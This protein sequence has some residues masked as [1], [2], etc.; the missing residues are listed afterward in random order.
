MPSLSQ[1]QPHPAFKTELWQ[2]P[3]TRPSAI[4]K[5]GGTTVSFCKKESIQLA[6][7][8]LRPHNESE[9]LLGPFEA[10]LEASLRD[11]AVTA[12]LPKAHAV[13]ERGWQVGQ[14]RNERRLGDFC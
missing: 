13:A 11:G 8:Q 14:G 2:G 6:S 9:G 5:Q 10:L 3:L 1:T 4:E 12:L 7:E